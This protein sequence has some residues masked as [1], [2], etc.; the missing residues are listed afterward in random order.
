ME[1][2]FAAN[3]IALIVAINSIGGSQ[4]DGIMCTATRSTDAERLSA[5]EDQE[6]Q[7][8]DDRRDTVSQR[9]GKSNMSKK[10]LRT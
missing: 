4:A 5:V 6:R 7:R 10:S 2:K 1:R 3:S 8:D 9:S